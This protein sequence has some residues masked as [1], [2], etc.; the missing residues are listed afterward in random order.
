LADKPGDYRREQDGEI[1]PED[2]DGSTAQSA[3]AEKAI[4]PERRGFHSPGE[5]SVRAKPGS[6]PLTRENV[7]YAFA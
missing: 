7:A 5:L 3:H 6:M 4:R 1:D 2:E